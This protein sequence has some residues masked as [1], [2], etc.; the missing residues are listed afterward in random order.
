MDHKPW[1]NLSLDWRVASAIAVALGMAIWE[2]TMASAPRYSQGPNLD[3]GN[4]GGLLLGLMSG[5]V[6]VGLVTPMRAWVAGAMVGVG[7]L[8]LAPGTAPRGDG[9]G[10]WFYIVPTPS[11]CR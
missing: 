8:V 9:D 7:A 4:V 11:S 5:A 10:L 6:L 1:R 2:P 3:M